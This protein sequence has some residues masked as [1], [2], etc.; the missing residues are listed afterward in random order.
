MKPIICVETRLATAERNGKMCVV[1]SVEGKG[2][3]MDK[4]AERIDETSD[5]TDVMVA[6]EARWGDYCM[7]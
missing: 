3:K 7:V 4:R 5:L 1:G 2:A 6:G